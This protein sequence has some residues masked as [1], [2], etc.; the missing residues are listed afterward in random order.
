MRPRRKRFHGDRT[1]RFFM[2]LII[3][4]VLLHLGIPVRPAPRL[5]GT[6]G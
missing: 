2:V 4:F 5:H 1:A 3:A 6:P